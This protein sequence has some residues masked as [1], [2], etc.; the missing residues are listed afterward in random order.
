MKID[1]IAA[2]IE[3]IFYSGRPKVDTKLD[4]ADFLMLARMAHGQIMRLLFREQNMMGEAIAYYSQHVDRREYQIGEPDKRG[5]RFVRLDED[6]ETTLLK[7]PKGL[8]VWAVSPVVEG[9]CDCDDFRRV[10]GGAE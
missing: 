3:S 6:E 5:R 4:R 2:A 10:Y 1:S 7:L 8:G 9:K